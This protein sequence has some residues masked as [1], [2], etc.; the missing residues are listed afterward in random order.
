MLYLPINIFHNVLRMF[1][2]VGFLKPERNYRLERS[3]MTST[4]QQKQQPRTALITTLT[5]KKRQ[6][7]REKNGI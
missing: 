7:E 6:Y 4:K 3:T 2:I 5:N 1:V